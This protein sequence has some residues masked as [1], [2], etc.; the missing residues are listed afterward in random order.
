MGK[1]K[2]PTHYATISEKAFTAQIIA[3]ARWYKWRTAH[4]R[5][6]KT[7]RGR[8]VTPVQGDGAGF[9]DLVLVK[10]PRVIFAELKTER[11]KLSE[12]QKKWFDETAMGVA[13]TYLW[14]P[15]DIDEIERILK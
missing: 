7:Q 2:L 13:E 1:G 6:G 15:R 10:R 5:P 8:W 4:F 14:R 3:L 12:Q 11:G 9:F